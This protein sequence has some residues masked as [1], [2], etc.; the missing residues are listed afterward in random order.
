MEAHT[1]IRA[2]VVVAFDSF[3][4]VILRLGMVVFIV[5]ACNRLSQ[6]RRRLFPELALLPEVERDAVWRTARQ[7]SDPNGLD[8]CFAVLAAWVVL[9]GS[10]LIYLA[11]HAV[12]VIADTKRAFIELMVASLVVAGGCWLRMAI[13][14]RNIARRLRRELAE[15]GVPVCAVCG[16]C[17]CGT[18]SE[19]CPECGSAY[20]PDVCWYCAG[21]GYLSHVWRAVAGAVAISVWLFAIALVTAMGIPRGASVTTIVLLM[22][23]LLFGFWWLASFGRRGARQT[24]PVCCGYGRRRKNANNNEGSSLTSE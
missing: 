13:Q 1:V 11:E 3:F 2:G 12:G 8:G 19:R 24:C 22:P 17:M 7:A 4:G 5:A 6:R 23:M 21:R 20:T 14:H 9:F 15:R 18:A 10:K 16:Y